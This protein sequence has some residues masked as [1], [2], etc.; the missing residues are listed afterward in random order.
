MNAYNATD[1]RLSHTASRP[2][3]LAKERELAPRRFTNEAKNNAPQVEAV[4]DLDRDTLITRGLFF[5]G[6][7][8]GGTFRCE[9]VAA[10]AVSLDVCIIGFD[11]DNNEDED[12]HGFIFVCFVRANE[13]CFAHET[14]AAPVAQR[15]ND[16][17]DEPGRDEVFEV[18]GGIGNAAV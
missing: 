17:A 11:G 13:F 2:K 10:V 14:A 5:A 1:T 8:G 15:L 18:I 4:R 9:A 7:C 12:D 3:L 16:A 6:G